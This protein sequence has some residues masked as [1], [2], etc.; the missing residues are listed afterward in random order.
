MV[1]TNEYMR[2]DNLH[3]CCIAH[4]ALPFSIFITEYGAVLRTLVERI[5]SVSCTPEYSIAKEL[6]DDDV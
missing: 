2:A 4:Y 6:Q 3:R 5:E 1:K